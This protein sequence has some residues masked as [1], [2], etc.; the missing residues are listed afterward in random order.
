[1]K[2]L[3]KVITFLMQVCSLIPNWSIAKCMKPH[4]IQW[5]VMY[6]MTSNYFQQYIVDV[7]S[8]MFDI[9]QSDVTLQNQAH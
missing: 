6:L 1:M 4:V 7:M 2:I 5:N 9:I 8:Q 3:N